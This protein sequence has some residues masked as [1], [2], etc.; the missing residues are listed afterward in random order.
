M[1]VRGVPAF[2]FILEDFHEDTSSCY[3]KIVH[4][5]GIR[6][7]CRFDGVFYRRTTRFGS[8]SVNAARCLTNNC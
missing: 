6:T 2:F 7:Y 8:T 3:A 4:I 1:H 5:A